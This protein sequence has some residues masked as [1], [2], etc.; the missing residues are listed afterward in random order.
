MRRE[1]VSRAKSPTNPKILLCADGLQA[2]HFI[3]PL[4]GEKAA[5]GGKWEESV[6]ES[7]GRCDQRAKEIGD[8][9]GCMM[10]IF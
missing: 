10:K 8:P 4:E 7:L 6:H 2:H 1:R 3:D 9:S 5:G